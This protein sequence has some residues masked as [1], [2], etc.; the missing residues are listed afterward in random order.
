MVLQLSS[1]Q[2]RRPPPPAS[3]PETRYCCME[4]SKGSHCPSRFSTV[5]TFLSP[6]SLLPEKA[7]VNQPPSL[8]RQCA[9]LMSQPNTM[10]NFQNPIAA[11]LVVLRIRV[12]QIVAH[13]S[14]PTFRKK[15][16]AP[17]F[18]HGDIQLHSDPS[19]HHFSFAA[20]K[21]V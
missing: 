11:H 19:Q 2:Q 12:R 14:L 18:G 3:S 13:H 20:M 17:I 16:L 9:S 10:T 8:S 4:L 5:P 21:T 6:D 7:L 15:S 1:G